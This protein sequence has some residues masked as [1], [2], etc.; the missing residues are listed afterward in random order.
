MCE[1][2]DHKCTLHLELMDGKGIQELVSNQV[3]VSWLEV[4]GVKQGEYIYKWMH[5]SPL[6]TSLSW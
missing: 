2:H 4:G 6:G 1:S 5:D 3:G